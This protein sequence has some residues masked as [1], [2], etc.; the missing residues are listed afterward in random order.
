MLAS[1][2]KYI[3]I[4]QYLNGDYF[5]K[6]GNCNR[7]N[8]EIDSSHSPSL[9]RK[10]I[11]VVFEKWI[12]KDLGLLK[13]AHMFYLLTQHL[14]GGKKIISAAFPYPRLFSLLIF[15]AGNKK[16][17]MVHGACGISLSKAK[18]WSC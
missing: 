12:I 13:V 17:L 11:P 5:Q 10:E 6:L 14:V 3:Y 4:I 16:Q 15:R 18:S 1:C 9:F 7:T 8:D 2:K